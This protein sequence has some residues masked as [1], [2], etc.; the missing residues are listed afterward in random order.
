MLESNDSHEDVFKSAVSPLFNVKFDSEN[1]ID[2]EKIEYDARLD[3]CESPFKLI[4][5]YIESEST[6]ESYVVTPERYGTVD[7][8]MEIV[9]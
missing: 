7:D 8:Y 6:K 4:N 5:S 2:R 1:F 9:L 3:P